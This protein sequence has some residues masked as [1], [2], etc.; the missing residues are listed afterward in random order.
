MHTPYLYSDILILYY[1]LRKEKKSKKSPVL[2][3]KEIK[4]MFYILRLLL[5]QNHIDSDISIQ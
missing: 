3:I 4:Y 5:D 2:F 1:F